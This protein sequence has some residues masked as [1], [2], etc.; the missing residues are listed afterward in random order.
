[1]ADCTLRGKKVV[2]AKNM[3][4]ENSGK[5]ENKFIFSCDGT[6]KC[7]SNPLLSDEHSV[8][9]EHDNEVE[10]LFVDENSLFYCGNL[11]IN[12]AIDCNN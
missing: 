9:L 10:A 5:Y 12:L 4:K 2:D 1:M 11:E 3:E 8:I 7:V 6:I